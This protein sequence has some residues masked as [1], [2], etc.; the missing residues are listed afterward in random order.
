VDG[1]CDQEN[2]WQ[3]SLKGLNDINPNIW[4]LS[5]TIIAKTTKY[6]GELSQESID[7][8][9][10]ITEMKDN[11]EAIYARYRSAFALF[12]HNIK[13]PEIIEV[14]K[15]ATS[16]EAVAEIAQEYLNNISE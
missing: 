13:H 16:D 11:P 10:E 14:I 3:F 8:L 5:A 6:K 1:F 12:E 2:V 4:D 9:V 7:R 15:E